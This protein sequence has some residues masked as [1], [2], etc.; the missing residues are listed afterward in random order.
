MKLKYI[1]ASASE[2]KQL[3]DLIAQNLTLNLM[4][5]ILGQKILYWRVIGLVCCVYSWSTL[6]CYVRVEGH[7]KSGNKNR[8]RI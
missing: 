8:K 1:S 4:T 2:C 6:V 5:A 7:R 3:V